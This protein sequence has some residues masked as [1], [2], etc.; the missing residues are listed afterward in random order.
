MAAGCALLRQAEERECGTVLDNNMV[1]DGAMENST[2]ELEIDIS[3]LSKYMEDGYELID[4]RDELS[5]AYGNIKGSVNIPGEKLLE[6]AAEYTGRKLL[7]YCKRGETSLEL[8]KF[9]IARK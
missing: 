2:P 4:V 5:F 8:A 6:N 3:E 7:L 1:F 9:L